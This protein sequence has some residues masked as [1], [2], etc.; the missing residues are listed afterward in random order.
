MGLFASK[1]VDA[2]RCTKSRGAAYLQ[3]TQARLSTSRR[4]RL[5]RSL[6][7]V[8]A[9]FAAQATAQDSIRIATFSAAL[10][11]D[12]PGILYRDITQKDDPQIAAT[13]AIIGQAQPDILLL[14]KFD[15]DVD[16]F[17]ASAFVERLAQAG[18]ELSHH[19]S[20]PPNTGL[21]TSHDL[22]DDGQLGGEDDAQGFGL[23]RG[24]GGLLLLS[25]WPL[26]GNATDFTQMLW[27][28]LPNATR[29][30]GM[31]DQAW[32]VQRLSTK[33]HAVVPVSTPIGP[34]DIAIWSATSPVFDDENDRNGWRNHDETLLWVHWLDG[35]LGTAPAAPL[36]MGVANT[37]PH[38]GEGRRDALNTLLTHPQLQD[39]LPRSKGGAQAADP[40][41]TGDP[42]LDTVDWP[43]NAPGNLRVSYILPPS[44]WTVTDAGVF[45]PA[46]DD[47]LADL[48]GDDGLAAGPH[49]LIWV[50]LAR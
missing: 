50:D 41:H 37:D 26:R 33:G 3:R 5:R 42:S 44:D 28:D 24:D 8:A 11:R 23:Y 19:V 39:P 38:D 30:K 1:F 34:L 46:P 12:G 47:P 9:F 10:S 15:F 48:L 17:A 32:A 22:N 13:L 31:S 40:N 29:P 2:W 7:L 43:D 35:V 6:I 20:F 36:I 27:S 45:W 25:R 18:V 49:R 4:R 21:M 14:T 16:R